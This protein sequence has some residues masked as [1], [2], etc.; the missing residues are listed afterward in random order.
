MQL[1]EGAPSGRTQARALAGTCPHCC[2]DL[3]VTIEG[4]SVLSCIH[5]GVTLRGMRRVSAVGGA[6]VAGRTAL[7]ATA[8]A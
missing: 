5:C 4:G 6:P 7:D 8:S 1:M 2:G 3:A